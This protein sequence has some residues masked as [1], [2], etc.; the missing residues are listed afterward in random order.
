MNRYRRLICLTLLAF[1][2]LSAGCGSVY[3]G[4][5]EKL[6]YEKRDIMVSRVHEAKN[7]QNEAKEQF[8][9]ALERFNFVLAKKGGGKL[10]EKYKQLSAELE[11]SESKAAAVRKKISAVEDVSGA[12]FKEWKKELSKYSSAILRGKSEEKLESAQR[13]YETMIDAM[14]SAESKLEPALAPFRD[15]VLFLKHNLNAEAIGS[16]GADLQ[17]V[18]SNVSEL[19]S[20]LEVA[21][22]EADTFIREM[23]KV[24]GK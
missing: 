1:A 7:S 8:K 5:M 3:Y 20:E 17:S 11:K 9:T 24:D 4:A 12:L 18:E 19:V 21:I 22:G 10:E 14:K 6:G 16:L 23:E 13:R 2:G 15:D